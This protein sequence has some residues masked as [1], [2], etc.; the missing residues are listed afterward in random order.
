MPAAVALPA[1]GKRSIEAIDISVLEDLLGTSDREI[2]ADILHEFIGAAQESW[3]EVQL[4]A[5]TGDGAAV[6]RAAH[7]AKGEA[8]NAGAVMLGDLYEELESL[9]TSGDQDGMDR[10]FATIPKELRRVEHF[11]REMTGSPAR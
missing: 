4:S 1:G 9:A 2:V 8:R 3:S 10:L 7:G 5:K 6:V 11:A